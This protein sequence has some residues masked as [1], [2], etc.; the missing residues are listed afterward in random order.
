LLHR[1]P[2]ARGFRGVFALYLGFM[3]AVLFPASALGIGNTEVTRGVAGYGTVHV[4]ATTPP[5]DCTSAQSN[6]AGHE[7]DCAAI[8]GGA[9]DHCTTAGSLTSC[10]L[11]LEAQLQDASGW[12]FDHWSGTDGTGESIPC[13]TS[14]TCTIATEDADC[15]ETPCL[16]EAFGPYTVVAHFADTR[17]PTTTFSQAP[18]ANSVVYSGT[19]SEQFTWTTNEEGEAPNFACKKDGGTFSACSSGLTWSAIAD[20]IHD[21]CAHGTDASGLQGGD[22][23]R[24]WEQETNPTVAISTH[25]AS[26]ATSPDPSFTY[27]SNKTSHPADG[28]SLS[29]QCKIDSDSFAPCGAS[30]KAYSS[31]ADGQHTF[32]V[33]AVFTGA[34]GGG[35]HTSSAASYTWTQDATP[36]AL[37]ID[38]GPTGGSVWIDPLGEASFGFSA[39]DATSG[40]PTVECKIDAGSFGPC[41]SSTAD[42]LAGLADGEH[43]FVVK[44]TDGA[45]LSTTRSVAWEQETPA[46][47]V[48]DSG[49]A[50]GS[51]SASGSAQFTFHSSKVDRPLTF[52]CAVDS[53]VFAPCTGA[54]SE[55]LSGLADGTHTL[56]VRAVFTAASDGS[57]HAGPEVSR[58]WTV[59]V[60][61]GGAVGS[62]TGGGAAP[63][64]PT[65]ARHKCKRGS[66]R[67]K[68]KGK[69]RCVRAKKHKKRRSG[70]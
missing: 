31:L 52:Q 8:V 12:R 55:N 66:H 50:E 53:N 13:T 45:G 20:G 70:S 11:T 30:G 19:Q 38:S 62:G 7:S 24:H 34:L 17:A 5:A 41:A 56:K 21:F 27:I 2:K 22:V 57:Q 29:Y 35:A 59:A 14:A 67:K 25:P 48:I 64:A 3:I 42:P 61:P 49:P 18:A 32:Q 69:V 39:S 46:D 36:P 15:S 9:Y 26:L 23:C 65:K 68:V 54:A 58:T 28:S 33:Q 47:T 16:R 6:A 4:S 1:A 63:A 60:A 40:P 44:A 43:E 37:T 51:T 10:S